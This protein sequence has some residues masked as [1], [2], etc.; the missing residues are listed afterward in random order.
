[1]FKPNYLKLS[2]MSV[3]NVWR[4]VYKYNI[5]YDMEYGFILFFNHSEI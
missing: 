4:V 2:N 5:M 1:M 3:L